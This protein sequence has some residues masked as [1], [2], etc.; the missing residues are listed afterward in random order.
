MYKTK[1]NQVLWEQNLCGSL[2][3]LIAEE[4]FH[5]EKFKFKKFYIAWKKNL[6]IMKLFWCRQT[7]KNWKLGLWKIFTTQMQANSLW[8]CLDRLQIFH[9]PKILENNYI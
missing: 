8:L 4:K 9:I 5:I 1:K 3:H 2:Y 6:I 7:K